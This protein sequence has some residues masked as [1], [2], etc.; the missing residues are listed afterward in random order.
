MTTK[1]NAVPAGFE[2]LEP[3]VSS[4]AL[5]YEAERMRQRCMESMESIQHFYDVMIQ[6]VEAA[7]DHLD[8]FE[9]A[10][11]PECEQRLFY[12]VL[13][14]VEVAN[15]VEFYR[16]PNSRYAMPPGRIIPD[17]DG[18]RYGGRV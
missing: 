9:L 12:L 17:E 2:D 11:L 13:S 14:L 18:E 1:P 16:R 7:L 3:F 6:R 5:Q 8:T 10:E 15:A 4:W